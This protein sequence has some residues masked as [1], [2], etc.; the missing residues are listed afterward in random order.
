MTSEFRFS[1][2]GS[3]SAS[4]SDLA[5]Y[6]VYSS[7]PGRI[8]YVGGANASDSNPG[9][10][11][12]PLY[13]V[14]AAITKVAEQQNSASGQWSD[15]VIKASRAYDSE[16]IV[17]GDSRIRRMRIVSFPQAVGSSHGFPYFN[18]FIC[19]G[20]NDELNGLIVAGVKFLSDVKVSC[21]VD[22]NNLGSER[23]LFDHAEVNGRTYVTGA[24]GFATGE[25]TNFS[26]CDFL[27]VGVVAL[28]GS[29]SDT[30]NKVIGVV[31]DSSQPVAPAYI[32]NYNAAYVTLG[33]SI[34][35]SF[36]AS[37][38]NDTQ[39]TVYTNDA[40]SS[41]GNKFIIRGK[42][43]VLN[44]G[45]L[46]FST[47]IA[48]F[49]G[50]NAKFY[51]LGGVISA[52][53]NMYFTDGA[54]EYKEYRLG[55]PIYNYSSYFVSGSRISGSSELSGSLRMS[56]SSSFNGNVMITGS[57]SV[58]QR[59][60]NG[61][62]GPLNLGA[63][64]SSGGDLGNDD[65]LVGG[66]LDV[67]GITRLYGN[68]TLNDTT[69]I[70][71]TT[72]CWSTVSISGSTKITGSI[73]VTGSI[74]SLLTTT[75]LPAGTTQTINLA[76]GNSHVID[77]NGASGDV[78]LTLSN[79]RAGASY[80]IKIIQGATARDITWPGTVKWP[81]AVVPVISTGEDDVDIVSLFF[82]GTNFYATIGQNFS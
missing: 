78:T 63:S 44:S 40:G 5:E 41:Y 45:K 9:T 59:M 66:R 1:N 65:V 13:T 22:S 29:V 75:L 17:I 82:D 74:T 81:D 39:L 32:R 23:F 18:Q 50:S 53:N 54:T 47:E 38:S 43:R 35:D 25:N 62:E 12:K 51:H 77:L 61:L 72:Y 26:K 8:F 11:I 7:T 68:T 28:E 15:I 71:G 34:A 56:G 20:S 52:Y 33:G 60:Y 79:G 73:E 69:Q 14:N 46:S 19:T 55:G 31:I 16:D 3:I 24:Y 58:T 76:N 27:N 21:S 37:S 67:K 36:Q 4:V 10:E 49:S 48:E 30:T 80:I 57:T 2:I 70:F 64:A 42:T 6:N